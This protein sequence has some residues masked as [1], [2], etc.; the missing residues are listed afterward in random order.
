MEL[1]VSFTP[2]PLNPPGKSTQNPMDRMLGGTQ[3][4]SGHGGKEKKV[5][6]LPLPGTGHWSSSL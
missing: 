1:S 6:S 2:W 4:Q 3:T 5:P